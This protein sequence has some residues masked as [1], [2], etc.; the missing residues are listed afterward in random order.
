[1]ATDALIVSISDYPVAGGL[2]PPLPGATRDSIR[3]GRFIAANTTGINV[4]DV[5]WP[6]RQEQPGQR[7]RPWNKFRLDGAMLS[8]VNVGLQQMQDRL[9]VYISGHAR[10]TVQDPAMPAVYC[11]SHSRNIPDLFAPAGWIRLLTAAALYREYLFFFDCCNDMEP[12]QV[13]QPPPLELKYRADKPGVLVVAACA[14]NQQAVETDKAFTDVLLEALSDPR[15]A[16]ARTSLSRRPPEGMGAEGPRRLHGWVQTPMEWSQ[17]GMHGDPR[18]SSF[19]GRRCRW[20]STAA[21]GR[22]GRRSVGSD[23]EPAGA[24]VAGAGGAVNLQDV[25]PGKYVLRARSGDWRRLV[26]VKTGVDDAG[27]VAPVVEPVQV[28]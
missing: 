4:E 8:Y 9:F 1:V 14:P 15:A 10:C 13:P 5:C 12:G 7:P 24:L 20:T 28:A 16:R 21:R 25:Y 19:C 27:Q 17:P 2:L 26:L 22:R 18:A 6:L 3:V 11:A 23:L